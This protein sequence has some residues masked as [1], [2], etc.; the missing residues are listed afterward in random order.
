M[1]L[2]SVKCDDILCDVMSVSPAAIAGLAN[3]L[4]FLH[5]A[6]RSSQT[7]PHPDYSALGQ[8]LRAVCGRM[9][10]ALRR[11]G[12]APLRAFRALRRSLGALLSLSSEVA[13][14]IGE[15]RPITM[16]GHSHGGLRTL[17]HAPSL[18]AGPALVL[19][20]SVLR[21]ELAHAIA[22]QVWP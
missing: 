11:L 14:P 3:A 7:D 9:R 16:K 21:H 20:H 8:N 1:L 22:R 17:L 4:V 19:L 12:R 10:S 5:H 6:L 2:S 18:L 15:V 13:P